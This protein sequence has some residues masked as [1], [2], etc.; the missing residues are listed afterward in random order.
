MM[1]ATSIPSITLQSVVLT[2][3]C[4]VSVA[5]PQPKTITASKSLTHFRYL[6]RRRDVHIHMNH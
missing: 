5:E 4:T 2:T 6:L 1:P 3:S